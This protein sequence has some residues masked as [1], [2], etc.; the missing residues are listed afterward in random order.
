MDNY[1]KMKAEVIDMYCNTK[2]GLK[3]ILKQVAPNGEITIDDVYKMLSDYEKE[4]NVIINRADRPAKRTYMDI[5]VSSDD[6]EKTV[7]N[8]R[9]Q[10]ISYKG[11][12][13]VL[14]E[15]DIKL[16]FYTIKNICKKMY[17][18][19]NKEIH[20]TEHVETIKNNKNNIPREYIYELR[21]SRLTYNQISEELLKIGIDISYNTVGKICKEI[22]AAKG[23]KEPVIHS[24]LKV[25][26]Y[27]KVKNEIG[28]EVFKLREEGLTYE[29]IFAKLKTSGQPVTIARV[30]QICKDVYAE[31]GKECPRWNFK[32]IKRKPENTYI[33]TDEII[34]LY[35]QGYSYEYIACAL[36]KDKMFIGVK[37]IKE[38]CESLSNENGIE[39]AKRRA[40]YK[41]YQGVLDKEVIELVNN[42]YTFREI[43][44]YFKDKKYDITDER[45]RNKYIKIC[46][47]LNVEPQLDEIDFSKVEPERIKQAMEK[48]KTIKNASDEQLQKVLESYN[49]KIDLDK[50]KEI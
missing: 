44:K 28:E 3:T 6:L 40:T 2:K 36:Y 22:Y 32:G 24:G 8:L 14:K 23:E 38:I 27:E 9:E 18:S 48:L 13:E 17:G 39:G 16:D 15:R 4:N 29:E 12:G 5:S 37:R 45:L 49:L 42:Q 33:P 30:A 34:D 26:D 25:V 46:K 7:Y 10:G 47:F 21:K 41:S 35:K 19:L 43:V 50:E 1:D 11:I 31:K 20:E